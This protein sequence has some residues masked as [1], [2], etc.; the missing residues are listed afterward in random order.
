[1]KSIEYLKNKLSTL[2]SEISGIKIR[3]EFKVSTNTHIIEVLPVTFFDSNEEYIKQELQIEE[4]FENRF[5]EED[6][7]FISKG[8]LSEIQRPNYTWGYEDFEFDL[9]NVSNDSNFEFEGFSD[10]IIDNHENLALAA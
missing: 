7:L 10:K 8:S 3:Y 4:D 9:N 6:I 1:M 2:F 5:P